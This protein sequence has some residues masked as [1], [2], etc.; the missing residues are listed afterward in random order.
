MEKSTFLR[1]FGEEN[2][3]NKHMHKFSKGKERNK[4]KILWDKASTLIPT[5]K[6]PIL[7]RKSSS[8]IYT[9]LPTWKS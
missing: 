7:W 3:P 5:I 4:A 1:R 8:R 2:F 9:R 6:L